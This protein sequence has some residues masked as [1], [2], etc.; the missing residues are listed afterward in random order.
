MKP[1]RVSGAPPKK[2]RCPVRPP[3]DGSKGNPM[4]WCAFKAKHKGKHSWEEGTNGR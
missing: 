1:I 4:A 3:L 2:G